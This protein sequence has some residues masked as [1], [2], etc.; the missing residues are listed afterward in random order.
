MQDPVNRINPLYF[1]SSCWKRKVW[2]WG[3][4]KPETPALL[5][6]PSAALQE[7]VRGLGLGPDVFLWILQDGKQQGLLVTNVHGARTRE[8]GVSAQTAV[9]ALMGQEGLQSPWGS[10]AGDGRIWSPRVRW[11]C[12]SRLEQ[13]PQARPLSQRLLGS[14]WPQACGTSQGIR[15][16]HGAPSCQQC[17]GWLSLGQGWPTVAVT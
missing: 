14:A 2:G 11:V 10:A 13:G 16:T 7:A 12:L 17:T 5:C 15:T 1:G 4:E 6:C 8:A 3:G 9:I